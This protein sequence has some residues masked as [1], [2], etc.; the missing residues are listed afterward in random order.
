MKYQF[1]G[2]ETII[3]PARLEMPDNTSVSALSSPLISIGL[4]LFVA[5]L[6]IVAVLTIPLN[7]LFL[8]AIFKKKLVNSPSNFLLAVLCVT[9]LQTGLV[10][11]PIF[12]NGVSKRKLG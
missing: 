9:D 12:T 3:Y 4:P 1:S 6:A 5:S 10:V 11:L 7:A 2:N 8:F